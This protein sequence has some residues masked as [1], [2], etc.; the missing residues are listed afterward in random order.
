M[1]PEKKY[2]LKDL[3]EKIKG[4][5]SM[6]FTRYDGL[7]AQ[8]LDRLRNISNAKNSKYMVVK[9][10]LFE[11]AA[12]EEKIDDLGYSFKGST[13]VLFGEGD[14]AALAKMFVQFEKENENLKVEGGFLENKPLSKEQVKYLASLPS[15]EEL[16]AKLVG[17]MNAPISNF[18]GV[19]SALLRNFVNALHQIKEQKEQTS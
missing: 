15:K 9:N 6:I 13:G 3:R 2:M 14:A 8:S 12:K 17:Q 1:R 19:L 4:S 18:V 16:I 10:T 11:R 7:D 5:D